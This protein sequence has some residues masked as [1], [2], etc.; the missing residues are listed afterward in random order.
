MVDTLAAPEQCNIMNIEAFFEQCKDAI[1]NDSSLI[2]IDCADIEKVDF[3]FIQLLLMLKNE[4]S[5]VKIVS[6]SERFN[7]ALS[8][9]QLQALLESN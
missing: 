3:T 5:E 9:Y 6:P 4:C 8:L 2:T 1:A 7:E